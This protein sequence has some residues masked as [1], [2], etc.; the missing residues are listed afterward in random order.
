M[1]VAIVAAILLAIPLLR[2][3]LLVKSSGWQRLSQKYRCR[4]RFKARCHACWWVQFTLP[5]SR[6]QTVVNVGHLT[7]WP[8]RIEFPPYWVGASDE[9]LYLKRNVWNLLH[10]ALLIPWASIQNASEVSYQELVR[11]T[12]V[13]EVARRPL[14]LLPFTAAAQGI[15]GPLLELKISDPNVSMVA[16]LAAFE[17]ALPFLQTKPPNHRQAEPRPIS[18]SLRF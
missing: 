8:F 17:Q 13:S 5:G 14:E 7:R 12:L 6:R 3:W 11:N 4:V 16:Q 1:T 15:S 10:P 2:E 9:G 18:N